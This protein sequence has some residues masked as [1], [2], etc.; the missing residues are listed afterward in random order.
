MTTIHPLAI[1]RRT[2][3][4]FA[5]VLPRYA[6]L[7]PMAALD[8]LLLFTIW[9]YGYALNHTEGWSGALSKAGGADKGV[10]TL[11]VLLWG[12]SVI[13]FLAVTSTAIT[14]LVATVCAQL[15][16]QLRGLP[17]LATM[18]TLLVSVAVLWGLIFYE[19]SPL[20]SEAYVTMQLADKV[21]PEQAVTIINVLW[22]MTMIAAMLVVFGASSALAGLETL[23]RWHTLDGSDGHAREA[24]GQ[25]FVVPLATRNRRLQTVL[26]AGAAVL[27]AGVIEIDALYQWAVARTNLGDDSKAAATLI[28][29]AASVS[30]GTFFSLFLASAYVPAAVILRRRGSALAE[31]V[32]PG[33][34]PAARTDWLEKNGLGSSVSTQVSTLVALL[35]PILAGGPLNAVGHMFG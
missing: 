25:Q 13:L 1:V 22:V 20:S 35:G 17:R 4:Q 8:T 33:E 21:L 5:D 23:P 31:R 16:E 18:A 10:Q 19:G 7:A 30:T 11:G 14:V 2:W 24:A 6:W 15:K 34:L 32:L 3:Q 27:V 9:I 12:T 26:F 29:S 28:T